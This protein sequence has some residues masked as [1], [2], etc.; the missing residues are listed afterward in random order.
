MIDRIRHLDNQGAGLLA[1]SAPGGDAGASTGH[2]PRQ[3]A[4]GARDVEVGDTFWRNG[5]FYTIAGF[6]CDGEPIF[7]SVRWAGVP[8]VA[9][10]KGVPCRDHT[11][12]VR[13]PA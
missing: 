10:L 4:G 7:Q 6:W 1:P 3:R 11:G 5:F 2:P 9:T 8:P 12:R 13:A